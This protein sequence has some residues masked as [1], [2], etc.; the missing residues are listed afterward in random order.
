MNALASLSITYLVAAVCSTILF[1]V[2]SGEKNIIAEFKKVNFAPVLLGVVVVGLEFGF[3]YAYKNGWQ[4]STTSIVQSSFLAIAL[5]ATGALL[6]H[7]AIT[8][9]KVIGMG[10]CLVGLF[11]ISRG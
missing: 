6:Y 9:S 2:T 8:A 1:F 7:E 10:I 4:V 3:I 5:I 11:F